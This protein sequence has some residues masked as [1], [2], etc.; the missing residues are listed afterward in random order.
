MSSEWTT[1]DEQGGVKRWVWTERVKD[2]ILR[3]LDV[4]VS[5]AYGH[6]AQLHRLEA[7][8]ADVVRHDDDGETLALVAHVSVSV[9]GREA[10]EVVLRSVR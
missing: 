9:N 1:K 8:L 5:A 6:K 10:H 7:A 2:P 3:N 4:P